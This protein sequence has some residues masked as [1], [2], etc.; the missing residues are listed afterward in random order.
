MYKTLFGEGQEDLE[1]PLPVLDE[2]NHWAMRNRVKRVEQYWMSIYGSKDNLENPLGA[3][4]SY[5]SGNYNDMITHAKRYLVPQAAKNTTAKGFSVQSRD[6]DAN[7]LFS[8]YT[9][10]RCKQLNMVI[11]IEDTP[12]ETRS[13]SMNFPL[14]VYRGMGDLVATRNIGTRD[15]GVSHYKNIKSA[16]FSEI[17]TPGNVFNFYGFVSTSYIPDVAVEFSANRSSNLNGNDWAHKRKNAPSFIDVTDAFVLHFRLPKKYPYYHIPGE[18]SECVLGYSLRDG[19]VPRFRVLRRYKKLH[20]MEVIDRNY[21][22]KNW[23][24]LEQKEK[25]ISRLRE[26]L[27]VR[28]ALITVVEVEPTTDQL[29]YVLW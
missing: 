25:E 17:L 21:L 1:A 13:C 11:N 16:Y 29:T 19:S 5:A 28:T 10:K 12:E 18:E 24:A 9:D 23:A 26:P 20:R 14:N 3:V 27:N 8:D 2:F 15:G 6:E 7:R 22:Q 4:T